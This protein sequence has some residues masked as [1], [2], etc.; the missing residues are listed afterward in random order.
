MGGTPVVREFQRVPFAFEA[1]LMKTKVDYQLKTSCPPGSSIGQSVGLQ[2][3]AAAGPPRMWRADDTRTQLDHLG[4]RSVFL[5]ADD[6]AYARSGAEMMLKSALQDRLVVRFSDF[7][8]NPKSDEIDRSIQLFRSGRFDLILA[9]GGGSAIDVAKLTRACDQPNASTADVI[10]GRV[11][12]TAKALPLLAIPT[13]AGTGAEATHFS[14]VYVMGRK[15]SLAHQS[16]RP[17][18]VI[19]S[20]KLLESLPPEIMLQTGLDATC[21]AIESSWSTRSTPVSQR[22]AFRALKL[23]WSSLPVCMTRP[24][25]RS[26]RQMLVAAH[27]AGRAIDLSQTTACHALSYSLTSHFNVSHGRAVALMLGPVWS[28]NAAVTPENV[29]DRR[30][31]AHVY[32]AMKKLAQ[33]IGAGTVDEASAIIETRLKNMGAAVTFRECGVPGETAI[34]L[35]A[36]EFDPVRAGNNPRKID[37]A[38]V[39]NI[40]RPLVR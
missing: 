2:R 37:A 12:V 22:L 4:V 23:A 9:V 5:V 16:M 15:Y 7:T 17:E 32:A 39:R 1:L 38:D 25:S 36:A 34:D 26:R 21:Q 33:L 35:I 14:A 30:G 10:T 27:L 29:A 8:A 24:T 18:Y 13:T 40:L 19:L 6:Q 31:V 20:E 3:V 28:F 11:S